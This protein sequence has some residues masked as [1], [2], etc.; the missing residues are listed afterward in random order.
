MMATAINDLNIY[1][2]KNQNKE[3]LSHSD[4]ITAIKLDKTS[5]KQQYL[6]V[7]FNVVY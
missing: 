1:K 6:N 7:V 2:K 4:Y 3:H 5:P